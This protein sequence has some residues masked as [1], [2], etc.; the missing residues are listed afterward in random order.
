LPD[1]L[2]KVT[3]FSAGIATVSKEPEAGT[4]L[5]KFLTS[6]AARETIINSGLE[7]IEGV[8]K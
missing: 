2:Q 5:I 1:D 4:A 7:P 6:P 3:V 8:T